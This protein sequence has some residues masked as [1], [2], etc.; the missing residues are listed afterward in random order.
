MSTP[1]TPEEKSMTYAEAHPTFVASYMDRE[2]AQEH[3][4]RI[5]GRVV[6]M[7]ASGIDTYAV[8]RSV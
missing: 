8:Y 2:R 3:A 6:Y 7:W 1:A 4:E 5:G